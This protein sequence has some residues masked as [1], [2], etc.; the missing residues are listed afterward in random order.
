MEKHPGQAFCYSIHYGGDTMLQPVKIIMIAA[1]TMLPVINESHS[2]AESSGRKK[3]FKSGVLVAAKDSARRKNRSARNDE[4]R[5]RRALTRK[6]NRP[7]VSPKTTRSSLKNRSVRSKQKASQRGVTR[8]ANRPK[9]SPKTK[10]QGKLKS[11]TAK[12]PVLKLPKR[13]LGKTPAD[14]RPIVERPDDERRGDK[15][16]IE[17]RP[18]DKRRGNK[19]QIEKRPD[20]ERR[21]DKRQIEK[22][23]DDKRRGDKRQIEKRPDDKRRGNKRQI[24]KRPDDKRR[25]NKRRTGSGKPNIGLERF[26]DVL[27]NR[28]GRK[29]D[30]RKRVDWKDLRGGLSRIRNRS[31]YHVGIGLSNQYRR[32]RR[33]ALRNLTLGSRCHWWLDFVVGHCWDTYHCHWWDYCVT[34]GYWDC[35]TPCHFRVI[36]CPPSPGIVATSWYFGI[37]CILIPD[38]SAYG[39]Q[40]VNAGSPADLAGLVVGDMIVGINGGSI[41]SEFDLSEAITVS[42]GHLYLDVIRDGADAP[43][44]VHVDLARLTVQSY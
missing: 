9:V 14:R 13:D 3:S 34:P 42:D 25:G 37:D 44:E 7:K 28:V 29:P 6:A 5:S 8:K 20:D 19:R 2:F 31:S 23:P 35:W 16:Q 10:A 21:G 39:I 30:L 12:P 15:R 4:R 18:D 43:V 22:R 32:S 33:M 24:E 41:T 1:C 36:H 11:L 17:K 27:R 40:K 26:K 38:L